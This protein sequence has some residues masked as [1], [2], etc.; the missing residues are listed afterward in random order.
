MCQAR[1]LPCPSPHP[2][3][4][5]D[6]L[7]YAAELEVLGSHATDAWARCRRCGGYFWLVTDLGG[8]YE[9]VDG[10]QLDGRLAEAGLVGGDAVA[11]ARLL[12]SADLPRGPI[13]EVSSALV[14]IFRAL[15]PD[16][17]DAARAA[18]I[19]QAGATGR[20]A[21][22]A[23]QLA[24]RARA[25]RRPAAPA[26]A[27]DLDLSLDGPP[28]DQWAEAG[29]SLVLWSDAE[30]ALFRLDADRLG[31]I[32]LAG[33]PRLLAR[34]EERLAF[35]VTA[36][37]GDAV[38]IV[39][40]DMQSVAW[41]PGPCRVTAL[42][43]GWWLLVPT[44]QGEKTWIEMRLPGG[45][46]R[47][48]L[49]RRFARGDF[50]MPP[51]RRFGDGWIVSNLL[52]DDGEPQA[53]TLFDAD[54]EMV[55]ASRGLRGDRRVTPVDNGRFW[56]DAGGVPSRLER[57]QRRGEVLD[58]L[59]TIA[60]RSS[61]LLGDGVV[62]DRPD[63]EVTACGPN[64]EIRWRWHRRPR[65]VRY[66][67]MCRRGLLLYDDATAHLLDPAGT[68]VAETPVDS[69]SLLVG[70]AGTAYLRSG[71]ELWIVADDARTL[72]LD[73][74]FELLTTCGDEALFGDDN[75]RFLVVGE[76]GVVGGFE[77]PGADFSVIGSRGGPYVLEPGRLRVRWR[78]Q[79]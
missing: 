19:E 2:L 64:G 39:G 51:P 35:A 78:R 52:D 73:E 55:A 10:W 69:A 16:L 57:W 1:G 33:P 36:P 47:V 20:W 15:T 43:D 5:T 70:D 58:R 66:G 40:A 22:A 50:Y 29:D 77:A 67:A 31:R 11:L 41:P 9:Y 12:S 68:L 61:W 21:E 63:H 6:G 18:A 27:F 37:V 79:I 53:L 32:P 24:A 30:A 14:E 49:P 17:D 45:E 56:A 8:K 48:K 65:G 71:A 75:G 74:D 62:V 13:W 42:D 44:T 28:L 72:E 60:A 46:P 34:G 23:R 54:F 4:G 59:E 76:A 38:A 3:R 26:L 25:H 7:E